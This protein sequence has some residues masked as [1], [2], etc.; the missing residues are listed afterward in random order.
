MHGRLLPTRFS[1]I[2]GQDNTTL[3]IGI[4]LHDF[5][6]GGTERIAIRLANQ[7]ACDG[8]HV[9][10]F[11]G[12]MRGEL[13]PLLYAGVEILQPL[14]PI[15]R[16][17]GSVARLGGA[18]A[19]H[20]GR[21]P[22][23]VCFVPG[24]YHWPVA[25]AMARLP[26]PVRPVVAVQVSAALHK[27]QRGPIRQI[28]YN[29]RMRRLLAGADL[30]VTMCESA[31]Y[32]ADAI[33]CRGDSVVIPLPALPATLGAPIA[34]KAPCRTIL[35]IGRLVREKGFDTL[36]DAF[37]LIAARELDASLVILG[38]GPER[39]ALENKIAHH[40]LQARV[41]MP[42]YVADT[43]SWLDRARLF[44]LSSRF[45]GYG[46]V[47]IEALAAG[48]PV[49]ATRC[50]PAV[51]D[52]LGSLEAG[53]AVSIEDANA[54]AVAIRT[55]LNAP[56]PDPLRLA[57]LVRHHRIDGAARCYVEAFRQSFAWRLEPTLA[58][59]LQTA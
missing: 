31:A 57:A 1:R 39:A 37:A 54:M 6:L 23:D 52:L 10:L 17:R 40:G 35:A 50:T 59:S 20:F 2:A 46:A 16:A 3:R 41:S 26:R 9:T 58:G 18:A 12:S 24:N 11:V 43:R 55:V 34:A 27:P 7:W 30:V 19:E 47:V 56:C 21:A 51:V 32:E 8:A 53:M 38:E 4:V 22:I 13:L 36:I 48:R 33:L 25:A 5:A 15:L 49:V 45:E 28:F 44:V 29:A 42:G 14:Q